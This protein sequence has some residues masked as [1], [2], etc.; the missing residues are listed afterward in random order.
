MSPHWPLGGIYMKPIAAVLLLLVLALNLNAQIRRRPISPP[1]IT[2]SGSTLFDPTDPFGIEFARSDSSPAN[3]SP[4]VG[5]V[6][7]V[8]QLHIPSKAIKEFERSEKAFRSGDLRTSTEHLQNAL[9]IYPDFIQAHN[10]LGVRFMQLGEYQRALSEHEAAVALDPHN[11]RTHEDISFAL[12]LLNRTK[13][14]EA[15]ARV[16]LNLDPRLIASR[17]VLGRAIIAQGHVTSES[18]DMLRQSENAFPD[19]SLVLA[20][21][22]FGSGQKEQVIADLRH[23]LRAPPDQDNKQKA[24]CWVAQLR[25]QTLPAGCPALATPPSFR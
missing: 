23:Y 24:E 21:V 7:P 3:A 14:A 16:A 13:E 17:Y 12:L 8:S 18:M 25:E 11:A 10:S 5:E 22:H 19:A 2:N 15:E 20:Q 1:G 4:H 6:V 9:Q